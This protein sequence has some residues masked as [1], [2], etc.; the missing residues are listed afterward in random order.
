MVTVDGGGHGHFRQAAA[1]ELEHR[2]L[3]CS[4]LH[5]HAVGMQTEVSAA[6][7]DLLVVGVFEVAVHD[8]L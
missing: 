4:V 7:V 8:L 5:G 6:A 3:G 1:D 2:H